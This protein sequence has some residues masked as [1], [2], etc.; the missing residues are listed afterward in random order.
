MKAFKLACLDYK[1]HDVAFRGLKF[2]RRTLF[3]VRRKLIDE[4][5]KTVLAEKQFQQ[6][7]LVSEVGEDPV[8]TFYRM[9]DSKL[10]EF[11]E[12]VDPAE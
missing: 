5:W 8:Q 1:T 9:L 6:G 11:D 2:A 7:F 3:E 4:E 10:H 12:K